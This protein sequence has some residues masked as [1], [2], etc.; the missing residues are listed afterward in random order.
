MLN[1]KYGDFNYISDQQSSIHQELELIVNHYLILSKPRL[2]S[3]QNRDI[4]SRPQNITFF[5][6]V[7][8]SCLY[9]FLKVA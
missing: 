7:N 1:H 3:D 8:H 2:H 6:T 5:S 9:Q 4:P